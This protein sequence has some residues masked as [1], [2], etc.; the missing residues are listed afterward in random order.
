MR[1]S[2]LKAM[3]VAEDGEAKTLKIS[4]WAVFYINIKPI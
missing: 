3:N 2:L 1:V 4:L